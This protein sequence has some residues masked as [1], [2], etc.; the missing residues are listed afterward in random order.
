MKIYGTSGICPKCGKQLYTSD[1]D[2]YSFVCKNCDENFYTIEVREYMSDFWEINF[3]MSKDNW[4]RNLSE[5][6]EISEKYN[7]DF[8][9][10]DD[11]ASIMDIGWENNFPESSNLNW[12]V[13]E[14]EE[15]MKR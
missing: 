8:L 7:C 13:K 12:F 1:I 11:T 14:I 4:K 10:Y 6:K 15:T 3:P 9:G 2:G 5:I